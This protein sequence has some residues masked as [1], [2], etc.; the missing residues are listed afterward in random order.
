MT[1]PGNG[2]TLLVVWA[3]AIFGLI[4]VVVGAV[5]TGGVDFILEKRRE[6]AEQKRA[7]RLI[8]GELQLVAVH[9][10]QAS[11]QPATPRVRIS[12][13]QGQFLPDEVW[14]ASRT[15]LASA[16]D[17]K[18]YVDLAGIYAAVAMLRLS[19]DELGPLRPVPK[20]LKQQAGVLREKVAEAY[21]ELVGMQLETE[22][23][24][25]QGEP[26]SG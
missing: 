18:Q 24:E 10:E 11:E 14:L 1:R 25:D 6:D 19:L 26:D 8:A 3:T 17:D 21:A 9:L 4:G 12:D 16:L 13:F 23:G 2:L 20:R 7:R 5:V 15:Q 22:D